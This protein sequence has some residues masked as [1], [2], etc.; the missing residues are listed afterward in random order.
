MNGIAN[1]YLFLKICLYE[2]LSARKGN[3]TIARWRRFTA[4]T[5]ILQFCC[6]LVQIRAIVL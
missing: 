6:F 5:K 1:K 3:R 4:T 2:K